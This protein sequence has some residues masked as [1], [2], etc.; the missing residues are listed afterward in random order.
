MEDSIIGELFE[1]LDWRL[2]L[3][4]AGLIA[5]RLLL[6]MRPMKLEQFRTW[7]KGAQFSERVSAKQKVAIVTGAN[8]GIGKQITREL[9]IRGAKVY[10]LCR[11]T[12]RA[13]R[14]LT[15]LVKVGCYRLNCSNSSVFSSAV[16]LQSGSADRENC[17][18]MQIFHDSS[19]G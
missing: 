10:M 4:V 17:G 5:L 14:G 6:I 7:L 3:L 16:R 1:I 8:A 9:N 11:D 13:H 19:S 15:E 12:D 2:I 18:S